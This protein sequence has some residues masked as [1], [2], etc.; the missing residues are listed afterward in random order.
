[1][2]NLFN[3]LKE[4]FSKKFNKILKKSL[5]FNNMD[6]SQDNRAMQKAIP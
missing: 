3:F 5:S 4:N 2:I 1:M 6:H